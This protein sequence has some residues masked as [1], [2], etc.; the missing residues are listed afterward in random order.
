MDYMPMDKCVL[1][2]EV[3]LNDTVYQY[4]TEGKFFD[5]FISYSAHLP[6]NVIDTR[7]GGALNK[8]PELVDESLDQ[9][10]QVINI[11]AHDTDQFFENLIE[12][13]KEDGLYEN[14]V[15]IGVADHYAYGYKDKE[16]LKQFS[17]ESGSEIMEKVPFFIFTPGMEPVKVTKVTGAID[18]VPTITNLFGINS[19]YYLGNDA[20]NPDHPGY[21]YFSNGSWFDGNIHYIPG[22]DLSVYGEE[23]KK[24][25]EEMNKNI[26]YLMKIN[27]ITVDADY[28]S[29]TEE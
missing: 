24:Y 6:Y 14:T 9:E 10:T 21:V 8:Y 26:I 11:L 19:G 3:P 20:F 4:M 29:M 15:I 17:I 7:I 1:D 18:I 16:K 27:D 28:F 22:T 23:N 25:I 2:S 5:F 13:L 12:R